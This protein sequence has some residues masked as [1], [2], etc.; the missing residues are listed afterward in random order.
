[1]PTEKRPNV[2]DR[3]AEI[4]SL[5][6]EALAD[7]AKLADVV[8]QLAVGSRR[9]RQNAAS[10]LNAVAKADAAR[11]A[12]YADKLIDGLNRPEAQTRW[13]LLEALKLLVPIDART[14]GKAIPEAE[15]SLFDEDSGPVRLAAMRFLCKIGATTANRS[16]KVWPLIDEGIQCHHGDLEFNDML[17]ALID[18]STGKLSDEVKMAF[19]DRMRFDAENGKGTLQRRAQQIIDNLK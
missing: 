11:L 14:C 6:E 2:S 4:K 17:V 8:E 5:A 13:E 9:E 1:M 15:T 7:D 12:P 3:N 16:D 18:F 10:A 19:A